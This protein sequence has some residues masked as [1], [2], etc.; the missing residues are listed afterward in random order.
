MKRCN[1]YIL[2][3]FGNKTRVSTIPLP[4]I[5][6]E[7]VFETLLEEWR[8]F[9]RISTY[10]FMPGLMWCRIQYQSFPFIGTHLNTLW[11]INVTHDKKIRE[12]SL[13]V[14]LKIRKPGLE[15]EDCS[16][17]VKRSMWLCGGSLINDQWRLESADIMYWC[18]VPAFR[19][20][21]QC[22]VL[23]FQCSSQFTTKDM[24]AKKHDNNFFLTHEWAGNHLVLH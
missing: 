20:A 5:V 4:Y 12:Y 18:F 2:S 10:T 21:K 8:L 7:G 24:I 11:V 6:Q 15:T 1:W 14:G 16:T 19:W 13:P 9:T 23:P 17:E 22:K 3:L